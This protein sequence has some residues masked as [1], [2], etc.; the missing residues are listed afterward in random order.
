MNPP[1]LKSAPIKLPFRLSYI[2]L[3]VGFVGC[4]T[5]QDEYDEVAAQYKIEK[6]QLDELEIRFAPL[7]E[8]YQIIM[9][10]RAD[11]Y[12]AQSSEEREENRR[13][14]SAMA[15]QAWWRAYL[16]RKANAK[17]IK[18]RE[19]LAKKLARCF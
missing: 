14:L 8:E 6:A 19:K 4:R 9:E 3:T 17:K 12:R 11:I 13:L 1:S 5:S 10:E 15:I 7:N 2:S 16:V 18:K